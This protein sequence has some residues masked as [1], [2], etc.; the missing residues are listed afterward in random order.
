MLWYCWAVKQ[1]RTEHHAAISAGHYLT[2]WPS[3][4]PVS[5][6]LAYH[7]SRKGDLNYWHLKNWHA[8]SFHWVKGS[9]PRVWMWSCFL[10]FYYHRIVLRKTKM[11]IVQ[12]SVKST[13]KTISLWLARLRVHLS[14]SYCIL[15]SHFISSSQF[16]K[17]F[18]YVLK[19][20]SG[21]QASVVFWSA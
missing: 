3:A 12:E 20:K 16:G 14:F 9:G 1:L 2:Q 19:L 4:D 18:K 17:P 6:H 7:P 21:V 13:K 11:N 5:L 15:G 8:R 10:F